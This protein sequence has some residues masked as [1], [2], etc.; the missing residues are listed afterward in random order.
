MTKMSDARKRKRGIETAA[1]PQQPPER[2]VP[3]VN[4]MGCK[5]VD[6][7][8][9][10]QPFCRRYPAQLVVVR[11][12]NDADSGVRKFFPIVDPIYDWCGEHQSNGPAANSG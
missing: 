1:T 8:T 5:F 6:I 11:P 2:P 10:V 4:C 3:P 12:M 7:T 9:P